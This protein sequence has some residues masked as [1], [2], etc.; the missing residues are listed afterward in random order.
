[1]LDRIACCGVLQE[2][3]ESAWWWEVEEHVRKLI[4]TA[5]IVIVDSGSPLQVR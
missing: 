3:G 2:Y 4:L 5:I 1:M